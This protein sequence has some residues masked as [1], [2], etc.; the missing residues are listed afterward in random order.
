MAILRE[1]NHE[2]V[3]SVTKGALF[4]LYDKHGFFPLGMATGI[5]F[6]TFISSPGTLCD[7]RWKCVQWSL[8]VTQDDDCVWIDNYNDFEFGSPVLA[9]ISIYSA[10]GLR[11]HM[12]EVQRERVEQRAMACEDLQSTASNIFA[13]TGEYTIRFWRIFGGRHVKFSVPVEVVCSLGGPEEGRLVIDIKQ[14][15][16]SAF[17]VRGARRSLHELVDLVE[18]AQSSPRAQRVAALNTLA[19]IYMESQIEICTLADHVYTPV[20]IAT[21]REPIS[22]SFEGPI[23]LVSHASKLYFTLLAPDQ[24][25]PARASSLGPEKFERR[26]AL[27]RAV[28]A[29][30]DSHVIDIE[31]KRR[32]ISDWMSQ[33]G[34]LLFAPPT[35]QQLTQSNLR[36]GYV[37]LDSLSRYHAKCHSVAEGEGYLEA[38]AK[39]QRVSQQ[40]GP[41]SCWHK[42]P[43]ELMKIARCVKLTR[44]Q[45]SGL[46]KAVIETSN[47][48]PSSK[49]V[50]TLLQLFPEMEAVASKLGIDLAYLHELGT[51]E[52]L[53]NAD[54][55]RLHHYRQNIAGM[56]S[57]KARNLFR[58]VVY[59]SD[60]NSS[61]S[62]S[63]ASSGECGFV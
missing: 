16:W 39:R 11:K 28:C 18:S 12:S 22:R 5:E 13:A 1:P 50:L 4:A 37:A 20:Y 53:S 30:Y 25:T 47:P 35:N 17:H 36:E 46:Q 63:I 29:H 23:G 24:D 61:E 58:P 56:V 60:E 9:K 14:E 8:P 6:E 27:Q 42:K 32:L 31:T 43:R 54:M 57:I 19:K 26:L 33:V 21:F 41:V 45:T 38:E 48:R 34:V 44:D 2:F 3:K 10:N 51:K 52:N 40:P 62:H 7:A 49:Q 59:D 55:S 15:Y